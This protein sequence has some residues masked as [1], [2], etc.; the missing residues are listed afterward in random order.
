MVLTNYTPKHYF[1]DGVNDKGWGCGW[2]CIQMLLSQYGIEKDIFTIAEEVKL[3]LG[4]DVTIDYENKKINMADTYWI[5]MYISSVYHQMG[6]NTTDVDMF[7]VATM[8]LLNDLFI[9]LQTHFLTQNS[10]VVVTAG[11]ASALISGVR[12]VENGFEVYLVDPHIETPDQNFE[13][14]KEFGKGGRGWINIRDVIL[15]GKNEIG[16]VDDNEFLMNSSCM[17]GF[18][19]I[20]PPSS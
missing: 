18:V 8:G 9:M 2:R 15:K 3:L 20:K 16:I 19:V 12:P 1:S 14:L 5:T 17:F 6:F 13:E 4:D 7:T 10:L 11:G